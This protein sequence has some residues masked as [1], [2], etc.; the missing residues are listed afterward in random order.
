MSIRIF[1]AVA[2]FA[3]GV[4]VVLRAMQS[5]ENVYAHEPRDAEG[6]PSFDSL[7]FEIDSSDLA[8]DDFRTAVR[9]SLLA[10]APAISASSSNVEDVVDRI[11][12]PFRPDCVID[13]S[14]VERRANVIRASQPD[15]STEDPRL[16]EHTKW[17]DAWNG[18]SLSLTGLI[19]R[20]VSLDDKGLVPA[21][22]RPEGVARSPFRG[23]YPSDNPEQRLIQILIPSAPR[24]MW[25]ADGSART[26]LTLSFIPMNGSVQFVDCSVYLEYGESAVVAPPQ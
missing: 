20:E 3:V 21:A 14:S 23:R 16:L 18:A 15:A 9:A 1:V 24:R 4:I 10:N 6:L 5:H 22:L 19:E 25:D 11:I 13:L 7:R 26:F 17:R 2:I 12:W 8:C